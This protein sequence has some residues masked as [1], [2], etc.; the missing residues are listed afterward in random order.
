MPGSGRGSVIIKKGMADCLA[1]L[2][3]ARCFR[4]VNAIIC[5]Q[6]YPVP[7]PTLE[8]R[9]CSRVRLDGTFG[10][11]WSQVQDTLCEFRM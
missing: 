8:T 7:T 10:P 6:V 4:S 3:A 1:D 5:E 11:A 2:H 9:L